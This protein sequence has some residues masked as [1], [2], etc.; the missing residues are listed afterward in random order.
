MGPIT[1]TTIRIKIRTQVA[2]RQ[3][4]KPL[5]CGPRFSIDP[6]RLA[7]L[8]PSSSCAELIEDGPGTDFFC[9]NLLVLVSSLIAFSSLPLSL[10][11][12]LHMSW[13]SSSFT[14]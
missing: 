8:C 3:L 11:D 6:N 13:F 5:Q 7:G 2:T 14:S 9:L 1:A 4:V 12:T 10:S